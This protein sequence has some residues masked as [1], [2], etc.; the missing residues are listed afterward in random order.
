MTA[1]LRAS[2]PPNR[3]IAAIVTAG[4]AG[5]VLFGLSGTSA[6][7]ESLTGKVEVTGVVTIASDIPKN[8]TITASVS[9]TI[10]SNGSRSVSSSFVLKRTGNQATYS[11]VLP[12]D[13]TIASASALSLDVGLSVT[14]DTPDSPYASIIEPIPMPANGKTTIVRLPASL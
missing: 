14:A 7:A 1:R 5:A 13:W 6:R 3:A 8:A 12:Y 4:L 10:Y 11:V 2:A 9:A